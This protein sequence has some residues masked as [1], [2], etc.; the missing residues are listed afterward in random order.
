MR[1]ITWFLTKR[2]VSH[3]M[4]FDKVRELLVHYQ[5][6]G[7]QCGSSGLPWMQQARRC[8]QQWKQLFD[9]DA[10]DFSRMLSDLADTCAGFP[11]KQNRRPLSALA[12]YAREAP[13]QV[14]EIFRSLYEDDGGDLDIR[15]QKI[16]AFLSACQDLKGK[17]GGKWRESNDCQSALAYLFFAAP[18]DN[19]LYPAAA[20]Q[21]FAASIEFQDD[22]GHGET[23]QLKIYYQMCKELMPVVGSDP[24]LIYD[25]FRAAQERELYQKI[26]FSKPAV[27]RRKKVFERMA[28]TEELK[29]Q[30]FQ[31]DGE[32]VRVS[33]AKQAILLYLNHG[34]ELIHK[35]F[36]CGV[37]QSADP[38]YLTVFFPKTQMQKKFMTFPSLTEGFLHFTPNK[39]YALQPEIDL[40]ASEKEL[41]QQ[42][43]QVDKNLDCLLEYL[44]ES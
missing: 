27:S 2:E 28:A 11:H 24:F 41:Q 39:A 3:T 14:R 26:K 20:A 4:N 22:W 21:I 7:Q 25:L 1:H 5:D 35:Q 10:E 16:S 13:E 30:Y 15:Q 23:F 8:A 29:A 37:V 32:L 19:F 17:Y 18:D 43:W 42:L 31:K 6:L 44:T 38:T 40:I 33:D 36:G 12:A 34:P 9:L